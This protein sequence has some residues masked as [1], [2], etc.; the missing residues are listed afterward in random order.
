[1]P[2]LSSRHMSGYA[3]WERALRSAS[4][5][6]AVDCVAKGLITT[7]LFCFLLLPISTGPR[8]STQLLPSLP[9]PLFFFFFFVC[10][11]FCFLERNGTS[12]TMPPKV[13]IVV[14]P[15]IVAVVVV[16]VV[17]TALSAPEAAVV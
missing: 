17:T 12:I 14:V 10:F 3:V 6:G 9:P 13:G 7:G 4:A 8:S 5:A 15:F 16:V 2:V 11:S 1:M